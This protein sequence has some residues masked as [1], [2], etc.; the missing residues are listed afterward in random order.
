[1]NNPPPLSTPAQGSLLGAARHGNLV[2]RSANDSDRLPERRK[3][4][5]R[6]NHRSLITDPLSCHHEHTRIER[7]VPN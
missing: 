7:C 6:F 3:R 1:M 5:H 4:P 2:K